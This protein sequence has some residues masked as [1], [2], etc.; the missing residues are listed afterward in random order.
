MFGQGKDNLEFQEQSRSKKWHR[1]MQ[2]ESL[3]PSRRNRSGRD[4]DDSDLESGG[5]RQK[6]IEKKGREI[7]LPKHKKH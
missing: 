7:E 2:A 6:Y 3:D 4:S 5:S 1:M